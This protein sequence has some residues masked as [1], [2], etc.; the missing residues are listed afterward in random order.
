LDALINLIL[1]RATYLADKMV[2]KIWPQKPLP[3][4]EGDDAEQTS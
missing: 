2:N 4:D 3:T 1:G